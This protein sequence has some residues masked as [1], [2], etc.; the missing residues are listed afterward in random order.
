MKENSCSN[1]EVC[2]LFEHGFKL[3]NAK[4]EPQIIYIILYT[5]SLADQTDYFADAFVCENVAYSYD[6]VKML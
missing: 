2:M 3:E 1:H 4:N 5:E 6:V